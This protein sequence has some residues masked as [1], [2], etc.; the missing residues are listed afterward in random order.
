MAISELIKYEGD[1]NTFIWKY[2]HEDFNSM[3]ELIVNES[4]EAIFYANGQALDT[5]GPG[6][7][8]LDSANIPMLSKMASAVTGVSIFHCQVYFINKTVQMAVKWGTDSKVRLIEPTLGLP[9]EIGTSGE[10]NLTVENGKKLLIKLVGTKQGIKWD[11]EPSGFAK[12]VVSS[13][14]PL[15]STGVKTYL[16]SAI[17]DKGIDLI[18]IDEHLG[19]LSKEL[20]KRISEGFEEY[21]LIIPEFYITNV[22]LPEDDPNFRRLRELHTIELQKRAFTAEAEIRTTE[23]ESKASYMTAEAAAEA[24]IRAA[25]RQAV[26]ESQTTE[27]E[28]ARRE[29]ERKLIQAQA[30]AQAM[31]MAGLA[32]AAVMQAKGYNQ[33]DVIQAE[34]QKSYAE[35]IGNMGPDTV[36]GGTAS[37][38]TSEMLNLGVGM[39]AMN[40]ISPKM[41]EMMNGMANT[42]VNTT[43]VNTITCPTCGK[44]LPSNARFCMECGAKIV[45]ESNTVICPVCGKTTP[46]GKFCMECGSELNK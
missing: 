23:A 33:K 26:L 29:A 17:K 31:Q 5:F 19:E 45:S 40:A 27:T 37:S 28:I 14:R 9:M 21:G 8:Q 41:S 10:M 7:Y 16:P 4:E 15:I 11:E 30:E 1:N 18:E 35:A 25:Q 36:N 38:I 2:P 13:F 24:Q 42:A 34:I 12:S 39:A 20:G 32:E 6:R 22:V 3:T 44:I 43:N 46:K